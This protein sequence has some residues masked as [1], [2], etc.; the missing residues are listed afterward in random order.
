MSSK[1]KNFVQILYPGL[2]GHSSVACSIIEG[3]ENRKY[4]H[5]LIGY[6]I[7]HPSKVLVEKTKSLNINLVSILKKSGY[8]LKSKI[9][10]FNTLKKINA[11][12]IVCH[13]TSVIEVVKLYCIIYKKKMIAVEHQSNNAKSIS[14]WFK[15]LMILILSPRIVYLTEKYLKGIKEK[16]G[17]FVI[18]NRVTIINNGINCKIFKDQEAPLCQSNK[19]ISMISRLTDLRDH[20]TLIEAFSN[21]NKSFNSYE[22]HIAGDGPTK[23][24]L[25]RYVQ[26]KSIKNIIFLGNLN[27]VEVKDLINR[28]SIYIHSSLAETQSTSIMQVMASRKPIIA[29]NIDGINNMLTNNVDALL[30]KPKDS[31]Q[32]LEL[33]KRLHLSKELKV[34]LSTNAYNKAHQHFSVKAMFGKYDK[35]FMN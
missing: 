1:P 28:T 21:F 3:D 17:K 30:F 33:I 13:S 18:N 31:T 19:I 16:F 2:G 34:Q 5:Y 7:E 14:D 6:G 9:Q 24:S 26:G 25:E 12:L 27:E 35:L 20:L 11:D 22:L 29:T 8:D 23:S 15:T 10:I 4:K 32:L